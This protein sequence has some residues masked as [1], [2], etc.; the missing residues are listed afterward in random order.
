[1]LGVDSQRVP[2]F[3]MLDSPRSDGFSFGLT[4]H[5]LP[6]GSPNPYW[7]GGHS[8]C[9][10]PPRSVLN[11]FPTIQL[12][13]PPWKAKLIDTLLQIP[14]I[15]LTPEEESW[16]IRLGFTRSLDF[17]RQPSDLNTPFCQ[18]RVLVCL[19]FYHIGGEF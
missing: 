9:R 17:M 2:T 6:L 13:L 7:S 3:S 1:M 10:T 5:I 14:D 12:A 8:S 18:G 4:S 19:F 16:G 11:S 15:H